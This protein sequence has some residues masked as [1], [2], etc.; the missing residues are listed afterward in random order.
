MS[1]KVQRPGGPDKTFS[2]NAYKN[3]TV[4]RVMTSSC[5]QRALI[6]VDYLRTIESRYSYFI[7]SCK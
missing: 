3:S 1:T 4:S 2:K 7:L 6:C 5:R